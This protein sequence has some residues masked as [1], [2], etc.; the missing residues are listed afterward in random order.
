MNHMSSYG[1]LG[2]Y[3]EKIASKELQ[4]VDV[5]SK[6]S[7]QHE[8]GGVTKAML[9]VLGDTDRK[10]T[11][12]N[13]IPT[14]AIY[15][16]DDDDPIA[17]DIVTSW[18]N[19]RRNNPTRSAE[20]RL[21]YQ[22][23][24]P[25][26]LASAGD[27]LYCGYMQDGRLLLAITAASSG[28]DAQM[29][30]LFGI[31]DLDGRFSIYDRTQTSVDVF[32]AQLL[33]LLGFEPQQKGELLLDDMLRR[34]NY[35]FPTGREFAQY[36][37]DSLTDINPG[38]DNP[39]DVVLAYYERE[40]HLFSVLEEAI[41]QHE[42]E[43]APFVSGDGK[44]DVPQFT[45]FYKHVRNRRMS[46]AGTSLEQH[47]QRILDARGISY[48]PQAV[49]EEN[50]KPDFLFPGAEEYANKHYPPHLLRMLAVK[51]ST[52]D[53]WRQVLDEA[54]RINEKHLLT[55]TPS[56]I[57]TKQNKQM[58]DKKLRLVMP[59]KIRDTHST[60]VQGNTILFSDFINEVSKIPT[61]A[62]LGLGD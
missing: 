36:A 4:P 9:P 48:T 12:G 17:E 22:A 62:D 33:S 21:Y 13:G 47:V 19:T 39:D 52:K 53:R 40:Y 54:D 2:D 18:Y 51:T 50:K 27:T 10:A 16:S 14:V 35:S 24:T 56:G 20:W 42:Y 3:I 32:A 46:R 23:C 6:R 26:K 25:M 43:E 34:W 49:T 30:W 38:T 29:R 55:I 11:E 61:L 15:L 59:K 8:I 7:N 28:V 45:T 31:K 41:I 5:N 57:S 1:M 58:M 60:E 37:E 44:I